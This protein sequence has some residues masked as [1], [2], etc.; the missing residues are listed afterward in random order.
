MSQLS[1]ALKGLGLQDTGSAP[2]APPKAAGVDLYD[3]DWV[4][5]LGQFTSVQKGKSLGHLES[6]LHKTV[7]A[8]KKQ[9]RR[10]DSR[11]LGDLHSRWRKAVDKAAWAK[12]KRR[13]AEL[14]LSD[15]S[16]RATRQTCKDPHKLVTKL[17]TRRAEE[18]RGASAKRLL[19]WL[20]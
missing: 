12:V 6:L 2:E 10:R 20:R 15:K 11:E 19:Q 14:E 8:L 7:K 13:F 5:L 16:Y 17:G 3:T 4:R 1:D 18:Y 9:G